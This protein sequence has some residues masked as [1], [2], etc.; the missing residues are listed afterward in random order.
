MKRN[1]AAVFRLVG[2]FLATVIFIAVPGARAGDFKPVRPGRV[3][4]FPRDH[5]AHPEFKTEW[6]YYTGS[7]K[8]TTE[9]TFG[10]QLTF[11]RVGLKRPDHKGRSAWQADTVYFAHLA[12]TDPQRGV[13]AFREKAERGAM[14][15]AGA[16]EGRLD[17]WIDDWRLWALGEDHH[18]KA[19]KDGIGL[20]LVL[21]PLKP[22][23]LHGEGGY[24]RKAAA[25]EVA[26]YYYSITRLATRGKLVVG[27]R[28][29]EVTGTSW[30]DREFSSSQL[31]PNQKGWD[32]FSLQL[33]DG[34]DLMLYVMRLKDG[35][36]DPASSG[37]LVDPEGQARHLTLADF[38]IKS[39]GTWRSPHSQA[40][41]PAGWQISL[42]QEGYN[43]KIKPTLADQEL[44]TG[45][46]SPIIY[47]EGQASIQGTH[48]QQPV[49]GQGYVELIGYAGSLGGR[50]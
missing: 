39:T 36:I 35:T 27:G 42:P 24:S 18:L 34:T 46:S 32:W 9:E 49:T 7:L 48:D 44:H 1:K 22:P 19:Q 38:T 14:G 50:F 23:V 5:G 29:L 4:Q 2:F 15:L 47:W 40:T 45:G 13:F 17:V 41:Y 10:Y 16:K 6:W 37:T 8:S 21:T 12:V 31:A 30:F 33:A 43:L 26:S 25:T 11:F 20:D 3:F 28:T